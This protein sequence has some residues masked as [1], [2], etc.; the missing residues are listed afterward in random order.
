MPS[1][2]RRI[3]LPA[4]MANGSSIALDADSGGD[5]GR[6]DSVLEWILKER[7]L[8]SDAQIRAAQR[9]SQVSGL[10]LPHCLVKMKAVTIETMLDVL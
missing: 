2:D 10:L 5:K 7:G 3:P 1:P 4:R 9:A 6:D 8:V